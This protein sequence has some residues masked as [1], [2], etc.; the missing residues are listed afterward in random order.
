L[1]GDV[2]VLSVRRTFLR[3]VRGKGVRRDCSSLMTGGDLPG[4]MPCGDLRA[5]VTIYDA[6]VA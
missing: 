4:T 3:G 5:D 2:G 1:L 6:R